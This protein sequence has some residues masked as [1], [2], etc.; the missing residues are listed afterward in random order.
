M[1]N[2]RHLRQVT[3][4]VGVEP[5]HTKERISPNKAA[6]RAEGNLPRDQGWISPDKAAVEWNH[7]KG[8]LSWPQTPTTRTRSSALK[9][10]TSQN[11]TEKHMEER[12]H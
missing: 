10:V 1:Q 4:I 3:G 9:Q 12:L 11:I 2:A 7:G 6:N 8:A 5:D